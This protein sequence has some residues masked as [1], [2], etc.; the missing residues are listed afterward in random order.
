MY[1]LGLRNKTAGP[2]PFLVWGKDGLSSCHLAAILEDPSLLGI[3]TGCCILSRAVRQDGT[4][5]DFASLPVE[6][7][8]ALAQAV[9]DGQVA[10]INTYQ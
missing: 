4:E 2:C 7:K 1:F 6:T 9:R 3:S 10:N 8:R 5:E